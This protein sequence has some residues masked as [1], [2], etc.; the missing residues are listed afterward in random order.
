[1]LLYNLLVIIFFQQQKKNIRNEIV[2]ITGAGRGLGQRMAILFARLGA[3]VI[4]CDIDETGNA[5]TAELISKEVESTINNEKRVFA[6]KC[7]IGN[8]DEVHELVEKIERDVGDITMLVNNAAILSSKSILD[9]TEEEFSRCLNV[10]LLAAY[11]LI[12][13]ILPSMMKHNH[14]HIVTMLGSTAICGMGN[15]SDICTAKFGLVGL[16]ESVNHELTLGGYDGIYTTAVVSHY[17]STHL[18]ALAK[19]HFNPIVPPLTLEYATK[20]IMH[21]ILINRKFVCVPRFYYLIPLVKGI[22]PSRAFLILLNTFI[23]P[24]IPVYIR[25]DSNDKSSR[26]TSLSPTRPS[27]LSNSIHYHI[28]RKRNHASAGE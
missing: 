28:H 2:L 24:K 23:N 25:E 20:K 1:M 22:L 8:R 10:N 13:Q 27:S 6:Y 3:I 4:L 5:Q 9:M 21:A 16:M 14:G 26:S 17:L 15:F 19:T 7:D 12:R 18:Y 11:W